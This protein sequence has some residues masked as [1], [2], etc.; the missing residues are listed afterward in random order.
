M[1]KKSIKGLFV[2]NQSV[3]LIT[4][5]VI[6]CIAVFMILTS[7]GILPVTLQ[8]KYRIFFLFMI[9]IVTVGGYLLVSMFNSFSYRRIV[10]DLKILDRTISIVENG[11]SPGLKRD[12]EGWQISIYEIEEL[13]G[14][15]KSMLSISEIKTRLN[16]Y[17][18]GLEKNGGNLE[19]LVKEMYDFMT[20]EVETM[21]RI[22]R[23]FESMSM[24]LQVVE[25]QLG[26]NAERADS[27]AE[28]IDRIREQV[29]RLKSDIKYLSERDSEIEGVV[30]LI[31]EIADQTDLLSLNAAMEAARAGEFGRG[32]GVVA[33]EIRKLAD[34]SSN[35]TQKISE[36]IQGVFE[37]VDVVSSSVE[38][39]SDYLDSLSQDITAN[40]SSIEELSEKLAK[41]SHQLQGM[42]RRIDTNLTALM[43]NTNRVNNLDK[44]ARSFMEIAVDLKK[45]I[46]EMEKSAKAGLPVGRNPS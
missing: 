2:T 32:F 33:A 11:G 45:V 31:G 19:S 35:A 14:K 27:T 4:N 5:L 40:N 43:E 23:E 28:K 29:N 15:I 9:S 21:E 16:E 22:G 39:A 3:M 26:G 38:S 8:E 24:L 17:R 44:L 42:E 7:M 18:I 41:I 20:G 30:T 13:F 25:K 12:A 6:L 37:T 10:D 36:M 34:R 1:R 46:S